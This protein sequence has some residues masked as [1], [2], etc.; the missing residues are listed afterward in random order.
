MLRWDET[1]PQIHAGLKSRS[2]R[3]LYT[4][5]A[6]LKRRVRRRLNITMAVREGPVKWGREA[7]SPTIGNTAEKDSD[8][9]QQRD[10]TH[11]PAKQ[12]KITNHWMRTEAVRMQ[13]TGGVSDPSA[14]E[15]VRNA[16]EHGIRKAEELRLDETEEKPGP[17]LTTSD[18]PSTVINSPDSN[19]EQG[20][21]FGILLTW[22]SFQF[23]WPS[24]RPWYLNSRPRFLVRLYHA[25]LKSPSHASLM[26][27]VVF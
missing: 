19:T 11:G 18:A 3:R 10:G 7:Q 16:R 2:K 14:G 1:H 8:N 13:V 25:N 15:I 22:C 21:R 24:G 12:A 26:L 17:V 9:G 6:G 20:C 23:I 27:R 5:K 4:L